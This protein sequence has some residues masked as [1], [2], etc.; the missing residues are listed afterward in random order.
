M[1]S[2]KFVSSARLG[3]VLSALLV[4]AGCAGFPLTPQDMRERAKGGQ[5]AY[6]KSETFTV[7][8]PYA[9]VTQFIKRKSNECLDKT[10]KVTYTRS[11]GFMSTCEEDGGMTKYI[12]VSN[13]SANHA[14]FYTKFWDSEARAVNTPKGDKAILYVADITPKGGATS[15]TLYYVDH[16]RYQWTRDAI[17][18]WAKGEDP[19]CPALKGMY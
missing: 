16:D 10:F 6:I 1:A 19:G 9:Q 15:I 7:N 8:R 3:V 13:I 18:A 14:E 11:C 4:L 2:G 12:P 17:H 5:D